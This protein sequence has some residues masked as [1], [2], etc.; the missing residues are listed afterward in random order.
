MA[1]P[2][3]C[4]YWTKVQYTDR[5]LFGR[6]SMRDARLQVVSS[7]EG[8]RLKLVISDRLS[9]ISSRG[10]TPDTRNEKEEV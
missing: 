9:V 5:P 10:L 7:G 2:N 4:F 8:R 3:L 6:F 1:V